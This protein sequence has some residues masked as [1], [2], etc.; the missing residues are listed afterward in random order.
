[1]GPMN[2]GDP[3][4]QTTLWSDD[5]IYTDVYTT[6]GSRR[7][8]LALLHRDCWDYLVGLEQGC[9]LSEFSALATVLKRRT[10]DAPPYEGTNIAADE[11]KTAE[12]LWESLCEDLTDHLS[13]RPDVAH[14]AA[15]ML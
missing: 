9:Q 13:T 2:P 6:K 14:L 5:P 12:S 4:V 10:A 7:H 11:D 3:S 1:D 15:E 8:I